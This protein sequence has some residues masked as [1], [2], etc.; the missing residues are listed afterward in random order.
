MS[1][2][3]ALRQNLQRVRADA[4]VRAAEQLLCTKGYARMSVDEVAA[5]AGMAKASLYK[6]FRSKE[7][8]VAAAALKTLDDAL[9]VSGQLRAPRGLTPPDQALHALQTVAIWLIQAQLDHRWTPLLAEEALGE[10]APWASATVQDKLVQLGIQLGTWITE[11]QAGGLLKPDLP[12]EVILHTLLA[13][14]CHPGLRRLRADPSLKDQQIVQAVLT[15][16]LTGLAAR[17]T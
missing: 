12:L 14:T 15:S 2:R 16:L 17:P 13:Q 7:E 6:L 1:Q 10:A 11:A 5:S 8:L 4:V 9:E 3:Q